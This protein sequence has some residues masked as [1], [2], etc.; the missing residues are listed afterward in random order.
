ML[1]ALKE[2]DWSPSLW[3]P[4]GPSPNST[5]IKTNHP[6]KHNLEDSALHDRI[7]TSSYIDRFSWPRNTLPLRISDAHRQWLS[8][9]CDSP[10]S[11]LNCPSI[12]HPVCPFIYLLHL[13]AIILLLYQATLAVWVWFYLVWRISSS[14]QDYPTKIYNHYQKSLKPQ[15]QAQASII[16]IRVSSTEILYLYLLS[17]HSSI[18]S[19]PDLKTRTT[20]YTHLSLSFA[21]Y[22]NINQPTWLRELHHIYISPHL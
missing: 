19:S 8:L 22:N 9:R 21:R 18:V 20:K 4:C 5:I 7:S 2:V 14:I 16:H 13:T 17:T 15:E 1:F 11:H 6:T 3:I 10:S 12:E